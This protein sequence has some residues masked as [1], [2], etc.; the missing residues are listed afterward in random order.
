M[1][2]LSLAEAADVLQRGGVIAYPDRSGVGPGLRSVRRSRGHAPARDQ[3]APRRQGPDP[4]RRRT[5]RSST[6][7]STGTRCPT[8]R[9][10]AVFAPAGPA[11]TPGSCRRPARVPHWITGAHDGVAVRVSAHPLVVA[12]C[13]AF[14]G[15]LVSTSANPPARRRRRRSTHFDRT[16]CAH[17]ST[18]SSTATPAACERRPRSAMRATGAVL[19]G[20]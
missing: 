18:A 4:D 2:P 14:G 8:D 16:C 12:L 5:A 3:A 10:E 20:N 17:G 6:A 15:P 7:C 19:R 11:R 9:A 13:E 1:T